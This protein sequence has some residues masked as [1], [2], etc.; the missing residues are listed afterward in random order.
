MPATERAFFSS[1]LP[2]T[3][4][5]LDTDFLIAAVVPYEPHHERSVRFFERLLEHGWTGIYLSVLSWMEFAHVITREDFRNRWPPGD[6]A[7]FDLG[8][9][10]DAQIRERYI[11]TLY[12][13]LE[14]LLAPFEWNEI[15]VTPDVRV[16]AGR[17]MAQYALKSLDALH[18][19]CMA[20]LGIRDLA[21]FDDGFRNVDWLYL[22]NDLIHR[23][24]PT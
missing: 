1:D 13:T 14:D 4:L 3:H 22:W 20:H 24:R 5:Y 23:G 21:S 19:A 15:S 16:T 12:Q 11:Q 9:W 6:Y 10:G 17:F 8:R 7:R 2:P 18:L